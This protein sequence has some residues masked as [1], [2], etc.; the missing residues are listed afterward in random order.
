[1]TMTMPMPLH[2]RGKGSP[3][4]LSTANASWCAAPLSP[5]FPSDEWVLPKRAPPSSRQL[6]LR[7]LPSKAISPLLERVLKLPT[8]SASKGLQ[9]SQTR[10]LVDDEKMERL[11]LLLRS[12]DFAGEVD[13]QHH[14]KYFTSPEKPRGSLDCLRRPIKSKGLFKEALKKAKSTPSVPRS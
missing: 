8:C 13:P 3:L 11:L 9:R 14:S 2:H 7:T 12:N 6:L 4:G 5:T 10:H 1:M